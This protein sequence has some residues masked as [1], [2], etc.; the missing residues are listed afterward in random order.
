MLFLNAIDGGHSTTQ[1]LTLYVW[2]FLQTIGERMRKN[3]KPLESREDN[4][5][6]IAPLAER[7]LT[8]TVPMLKALQAI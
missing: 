4:L 1:D 8:S 5:A 2:E 7:F 6:S 3:G